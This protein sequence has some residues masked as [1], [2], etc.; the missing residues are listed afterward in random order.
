MP[1]REDLQMEWIVSGP[2]ER[3]SFPGFDACAIICEACPEEWDTIRDLT[4]VYQD[5]GKRYRLFLEAAR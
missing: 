1:P 5:E 4:P 3:Y 2:T